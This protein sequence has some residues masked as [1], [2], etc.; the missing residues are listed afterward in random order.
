MLTPCNIHNRVL[1]FYQYSPERENTEP[2]NKLPSPAWAAISQLTF[3]NTL[4]AV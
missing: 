1:S 3:F 4:A 2:P